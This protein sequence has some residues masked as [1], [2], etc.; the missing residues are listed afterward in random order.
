V[1][2]PV[3][4]QGRAVVAPDVLL[5]VRDVRVQFKLG[6]HRVLRAVDG[7]SFDLRRGETLGIIGESGSG[8]STLARAVI[9]LEPVT[10]GKIALEGTET[11]GMSRRER[12]RIAERMQ[13]IFQDP[14]EALD[15]HLTARAAIAE[16]LIVQGKLSGR[17][18][19]HRVDE[20]LE[21]V[22]LSAH[23][24][25]RR[26][27][28]LSGGQ[29]QRVNIARALTLDPEVLICDEAVSALDVSIQAEILNLL[30]DL[31]D[32][33]GLAYLFI[34]HDIGVVARICDRVGVMY[35]GGL[36][37]SA[38]ART[39][40]TQ[41]LHPYTESLLS[42]E[43]QALPS[44]LRSRERV[45]L[46]GEMPSPIDP[47]TGCRFRTRC[48][49]ARDLCETPP[50]LRPLA[51]ERLVAC[52]FAEELDLGGALATT[53]RPASSV[54]APPTSKETPA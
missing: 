5:S 44:R 6:G 45:L 19:D 39:L 29:R 22:G 1:T 23:H 49:Y 3:D 52:H 9:G 11:Q 51:P 10:S 24:G 42:A 14:H 48:R 2:G 54:A 17:D 15:P 16:P 33:R 46:E 53:A 18:I 28:E 26:P 35:L 50:P 41:P 4:H 20:V 36:V 32:E 34:S 12:R 7:V 40:V 21:R 37:E 30:I 8:K 47:P 43:P 13:M 27:H 38:N 31:Q 25:R